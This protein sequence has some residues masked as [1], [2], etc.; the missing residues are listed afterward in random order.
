M[1]LVEHRTCQRGRRKAVIEYETP[2]LL[3]GMLSGANFHI[4]FTN[5]V[6]PPSGGNAIMKSIDHFRLSY[7]RSKRGETNME[8]VERA[9]LISQMSPE[10][11]EQL[12][13]FVRL[14]ESLQGRRVNE[15][16]NHLSEFRAKLLDALTQNQVFR[17]CPTRVVG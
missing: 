6:T 14:A 4:N 8:V 17:I 13:F 16:V 5:D 10:Q 1:L 15:H 7:Q 2:V 11:R 3:R 9:V 12:L